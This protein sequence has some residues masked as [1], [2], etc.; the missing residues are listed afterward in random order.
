MKSMLELK[1]PQ[2]VA[3]GERRDEKNSCSYRLESDW[4]LE[5]KTKGKD[6]D[7]PFTLFYPNG[8][9]A[10]RGIFDTG[11]RSGDWDYFLPSGEKIDDRIENL[12]LD[13]LDVFRQCR[14]DMPH[15][16]MPPG[17]LH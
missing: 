12:I 1:I 17:A 9:P 15:A 6:F 10:I 7:G 13:F 3:L 4:C 14:F 2:V 16:S 11:N 8:K 5:L